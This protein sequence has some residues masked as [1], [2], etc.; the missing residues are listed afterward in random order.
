[1]EKKDIKSMPLALLQ[2]ELATRGEKEKFLR[3]YMEK[4]EEA[5]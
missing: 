2:E 4:E 3:D 5:L 1:M